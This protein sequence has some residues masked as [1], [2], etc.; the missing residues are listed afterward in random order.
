VLVRADRTEAAEAGGQDSLRTPGRSAGRLRRAGGG[1]LLALALAAW[2][3][4]CSPPA[5]EDGAA[6]VQL[7]LATEPSPPVTGPV[8]LVLTL[9]DAS[10]AP[11]AGASLRLEANMSHAGMTPVLAQPADL[12][13]G[14]Y[15]ADVELG[16]GGDWFVLVDGT[17]PDGRGLH[18]K[19]DLPGVRPR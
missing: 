15:A 1:A 12:G 13:G 11:L 14:R 7:A 5:A 19:L 3:A 9:A 10:G 6:D 2:P 8:R 4:A 16:M 17:L 18:R